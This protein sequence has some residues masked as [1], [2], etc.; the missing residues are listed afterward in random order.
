MTFK[1]QSVFVQFQSN[2][3]F[4]L[5]FKQPVF[6]VLENSDYNYNEKHR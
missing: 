6:P 1:S 4:R 5:E 3:P 2:I